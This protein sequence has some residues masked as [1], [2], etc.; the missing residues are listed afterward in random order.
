MT[1]WT[2]RACQSTSRNRVSL[3]AWSIVTS[4]S[5]LSDSND[6]GIGGDG[7]TGG[8]G[9]GYLAGLLEAWL[10][11]SHD[12]GE[13]GGGVG[14]EGDLELRHCDRSPSS[15]RAPKDRGKSGVIGD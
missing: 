8:I 14:G 13:G 5:A 3:A 7:G 15:E 12:R 1:S 10:R 9:L 11:D 4:R 6:P 2:G